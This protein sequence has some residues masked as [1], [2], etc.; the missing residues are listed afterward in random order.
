MTITSKEANKYI[1]EKHSL[2]QEKDWPQAVINEVHS[3]DLN[4]QDLGRK[5]LSK[6]PFITIDG[7]DA[8]DFD[9]AVYCE[10]NDAGYK[11]QVAIADVTLYVKNNSAIDKEA[12]KRGTSIYLPNQVIPM[13]PE[14]LSND[15]CSL[16]PN[17]YRPAFVITIDV[18]NHGQILNYSFCEAIIRSHHR[19]TYEQINSQSLNRLNLSNEVNNSISNLK[20][21]AIKRLEIKSQRNAIEFSPSEHKIFFDK[22]D[23]VRKIELR[24]SS[25]PHQ[26]IEECMLIANECTAE[27]LKQSLGFCPY[28][29]HKEPDEIKINT[30]ISI[31]G[32]NDSKKSW[33]A[34]KKIQDILT[35]IDKKDFFSQI[36]LLQ[37][38]QRAEYSTEEV[39]HFGLQLKRYC[40][41]TSPIRRYPDL[42]IHK[43]VKQALKINQK[44]IISQQGLQTICEESSQLEL[45]AEKISRELNQILI[46]DYLKQYQGESFKG[47]VSGVTDF[48]LF[49]TIDRFLVSGL[50]HVTDLKKDRYYISENKKYL[51]GKRSGRKYSFGQKILVKI[52]SVTPFEGKM[53]LS[54]ES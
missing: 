30:L 16:K 20:S 53:S 39:G 5:D 29:I 15:L 40:H 18:N 7:V 26:M 1:I 41:F 38:M 28:R 47:V 17:K 22:K 2:P 37:S 19:L 25:L 51:V 27:F 42:V 46:F 14:K 31:L 52:T 43:L 34:I 10:S 32:S 24:T 44:R 54:L 3:I 35:N 21:L 45:R 33:S 50:I 36:L 48:G 11:L 6:T 4:I 49:V 13:L 9:D 12:L 23:N 8:K